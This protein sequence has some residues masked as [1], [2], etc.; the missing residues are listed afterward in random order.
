MVYDCERCGKRVDTNH[1]ITVGEG[2]FLC[3]PCLEEL[4]PDAASHYKEMAKRLDELRN[5]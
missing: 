3:L 4:D 1:P 5:G 2:T